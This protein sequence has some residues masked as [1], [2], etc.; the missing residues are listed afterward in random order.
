[1]PGFPPVS[2]GGALSERLGIGGPATGLRAKFEFQRAAP[3]ESWVRKPELV[4]WPT[5]ELCGLNIN[6]QGGIVPGGNGKGFAGEIALIEPD[7]HA[8][9]YGRGDRS[10]ERR[11]GKGGRS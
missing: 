1:M 11:V 9:E 5:V 2:C 4:Q 3:H 7:G 6:V 10:E 8:V